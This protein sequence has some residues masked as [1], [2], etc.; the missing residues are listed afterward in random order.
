[1]VSIIVPVYNTSNEKIKRCLDSIVNQTYDLWECI[2]VD[3]GSTYST[4]E[5][6]EYYRSCLTESIQSKVFIYHKKNGGVSSARNYGL[7]RATGI[8][9]AFVDCDDYLLSCHLD[10]MI[11][12]S[13]DKVD[14]IMTGYERLCQTGSLI[15]RYDRNVYITDSQKTEFIQ[16]TDFLKHQQPWDRLYRRSVIST[17]EL[18]FDINM[19]LSEDRLF[20]YEYLLRCKGIATIEEVTYIYDAT[21]EDSLSSRHYSSEMNFYRLQVFKEIEPRLVMKYNL[22][23]LE[24][25]QF[26]TGYKEGIYAS[27]INAYKCEGKMLKYFLT[28]LLHKMR[29]I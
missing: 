19:S 18:F 13:S 11:A 5:Y 3:D 12:V 21:G 20:C 9:V 4:F 23:S 27:L 7:K 26:F 8:W 10:K 28:R 25:K 16:R 24:I 6:L 22:C 14:I 17:K 15:H 2:I 1:M 29:L